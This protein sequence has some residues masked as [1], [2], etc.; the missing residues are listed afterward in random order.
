MTT[1]YR[2]LDVNTRLL[3]PTRGM[4]P[5]VTG[6]TIGDSNSL[7]IVLKY[8]DRGE[9]VTDSFLRTRYP[10]ISFD[11]GRAD[12]TVFTYHPN[13]TR[14]FN[15]RVFSVPFEVTSLVR[16]YLRF[17][18]SFVDTGEDVDFTDP[19]I[20]ISAMYSERIQKPDALILSKVDSL[21]MKEGMG[22]TPGSATVTSD[23]WIGWMSNNA[24]IGVT[25]GDDEKT[26]TFRSKTG[27]PFSV[28]I[29]AYTLNDTED[30]SDDPIEDFLESASEANGLFTAESVKLLLDRVKN[31]RQGRFG[32]DR[33]LPPGRTRWEEGDLSFDTVGPGPDRGDEELAT[34][35]SVKGLSD[36]LDGESSRR[37]DGDSKVLLRARHDLETRMHIEEEARKTADRGIMETVRA[38]VEAVDGLGPDLEKAV[39]YWRDRAT[40]NKYV[41]NDSARI[42]LDGTLEQV[43]ARFPTDVVGV[44]WTSL[45]GAQI[46][47]DWETDG[48]TVTVYGTDGLTGELEV[49]VMRR[50][51]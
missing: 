11:V 10:Y 2:T 36:R 40:R 18:L 28:T 49:T 1:I 13:S 15:G 7:T 23:L 27:E 24:V 34:V 50:I 44:L 16:N 37:A 26:L 6:G 4:D 8:V 46:A 3:S 48:P 39:G 45:D 32:R 20:A 43:E 22:T 35:A 33:G 12:G 29:P 41:P 47:T 9:D 5:S 21:V 31:T 14:S 17:Q 19:V 25:V 42:M 38:V 30:V 51:D